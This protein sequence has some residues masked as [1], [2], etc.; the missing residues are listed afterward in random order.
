LHSS[1]RAVFETRR[2]IVMWRKRCQET[3][4]KTG[5]RWLERVLP[6][7]H[8]CR[9]RGHPTFPLLVEAAPWLFQ[10]ESPDLSWLTQHERLPVPAAP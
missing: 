10:G 3:C 6:S 5:N 9:I 4:S 1:I 2:F 7:R 8:T